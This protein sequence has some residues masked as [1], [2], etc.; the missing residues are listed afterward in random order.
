M[1]AI[2]ARIIPIALGNDNFSFSIKILNKTVTTGYKAVNETIILA[3]YFCKIK[4]QIIVPEKPTT[5][6]RIINRTPLLISSFLG[7]R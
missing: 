4:Y 5:V 1:P 6:A 7:N 3:L 2:I